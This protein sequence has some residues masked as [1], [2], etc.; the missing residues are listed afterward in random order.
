MLEVNNVLFK[1]PYGKTHIHLELPHA[2]L[3]AP[4]AIQAAT[5][6]TA[7]VND[8]LDG[9]VLENFKQAKTVAI[10]IN[11][12]T[13]PV[14]HAEL[15]PPLLQRLE[16]MGLTPTL[17]IATGTHPPMTPD[18]FHK[19]LPPDIV[20]RFPVISHNAEKLDTL[21]Y[22]GDTPHGTPVE[23]NRLYAQADFKIVV[24]NIEPH[25]FVGFSGGVKTAAIGL[26]GKKTINHNHALMTDPASQLAEYDTNPA[27]QDVEAI[28]RI[29]GIDFALNAIL[30][31]QKQVVRIFAGDPGEVM[32]RG[33]PIVRSLY[34]VP[35]AESYDIVVA[36]PGGN[37]KDINLYQTQKALAH[38]AMM[39]KP[40]GTVILVAACPEGTG[41]Q[42][43]EKWMIEGNMMSYEA[44]FTRFEAEG[45]QVG[46]HKAFQIARDATKVRTF[47]LSEMSD[48][49][50]RSLLLEPIHSIEEALAQVSGE[51][52]AIMPLA[53]ATIPFLTAYA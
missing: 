48:E 19:I 1:I 42:T 39:T 29:I 16:K 45:F 6:P 23:I 22:L 51:R 2:D 24:G 52:I 12:K 18:E 7:L 20:E 33:I 40:G 25:Q 36:S 49:F 3:I 8:A 31:E 5:N 35:I 14:P 53:N 10:A 4:K 26:A 32:Q 27:R 15:L 11:D 47:L 21:I 37:P 28:G 41:S 30:N 44:V 17:V 46:P 50:V 9:A 43:Y 13:R 38:A 34:Q